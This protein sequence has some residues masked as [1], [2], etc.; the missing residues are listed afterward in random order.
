MS[1]R[2]SG[3]DLRLSQSWVWTADAEWR[4]RRA[5]RLLL[6]RRG[7]AGGTRTGGG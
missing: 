5:L 2:T 6:A 4:W 1:R 7:G 3:A